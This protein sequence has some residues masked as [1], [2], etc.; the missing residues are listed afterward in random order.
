MQRSLLVFVLNVH[1]ST[2]LQED[3]TDGHV[4][5]LNG[6]VK[7]RVL[8]CVLMVYKLSEF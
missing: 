8:V 4:T 3:L 5:F 1:V 2:V 7:C 6:Y